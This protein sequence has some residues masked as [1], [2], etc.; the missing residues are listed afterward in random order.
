MNKR[1]IL[2]IITFLFAIG[3]VFA[4]NVY[5]SRAKAIAVEG[6][7]GMGKVYMC[8][9]P[10][11]ENPQYGETDNEA[12]IKI[13]ASKENE[14]IKIY[15]FAEPTDSRLYYF[16]GWSKTV[17][18]TPF[19]KDNPCELIV[20]ASQDIN[21]VTTIYAQF[22]EKDEVSITIEDLDIGTVTVTDGTDSKTNN[23]TL[24]TREEVFLSAAP[25]Q[26]KKVVGWYKRNGTQKEFFSFEPSLKYYFRSDVTIGVEFTDSVTP[27]FLHKET[28]TPYLDLND[29]LA[30][31]NRDKKGTVVLI[32]DGTLPK[33]EGDYTI[34]QGV[35]MLIPYDE[36]YTVFTVDS[37][38]VRDFVDPTPYKTL[39]LADGV[40]IK[41]E[42]VLNVS[43]T[44]HALNGNPGN[45]DSGITGPYG[46]IRMEKGSSIDIKNGGGLYTWGYITGNGC[47]TANY[48]ATVYELF[49]IAA[50]RGGSAS[51]SM[52]N[53][54]ENAAKKVFPFS[55]YYV[56]NIE[57]PLTVN[58]GA[59]EYV[60]TCISAEG[61]MHVPDPIPYIAQ[62]GM[63]E[64]AEGSCATK[65]YDS[66]CDRQMYEINGS[67]S[68]N[69]ISMTLASQSIKSNNFVMPIT[70]NMTIFIDKGTFTINNKTAISL[71]PGVELTVKE[72]AIL[73][74]KNAN[75]YVYDSKEWNLFNYDHLAIKPPYYIPTPHYTR[76][77]E[78]LAD[79]KLDIQG[80]VTSTGTGCLYT[81]EHAASIC[82]TDGCGVI[83]NINI[84]EEEVTYQVTQNN[85]EVT[86]VPISI[87]PAKL[88]NPLTDGYTSILDATPET[89]YYYVHGEWKTENTLPEGIY[90]G[91]V[92]KDGKLDKKDVETLF[93]LISGKKVTRYD[94]NNADVNNDGQYTLIDLAKLIEKMKKDAKF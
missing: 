13:K 26:G 94:K 37:Q 81:T 93:K 87:T 76:T 28:N 83:D 10:E 33:I 23:Q 54:S 32:Q 74:I 85:T 35:T 91:D 8:D 24:K 70:N 43:S 49:Q 73:D 17:D 86:Y 84:G 11:G 16:N 19:T 92:Y 90:F 14:D 52:C 71:L 64:L 9:N 45:P 6:K 77:A 31:A 46:H 58:Y 40:K 89:T 2:V 55:Q 1:L 62:G 79:A 12:I 66:S 39:T 78:T 44:I 38:T 4:A 75:V 59:T 42:G 7:A 15:A 29:A 60:V 3:H 20:K 27:V 80:R 51:S 72:N 5:Y 36:E 82:C 30:A 22:L 69:D 34:P 65:W 61:V 48:G 57:V 63:F 53:D 67:A 50:F 21:N 88:Y 47:V 56:Q 41:V 18:G 68:M 25:I